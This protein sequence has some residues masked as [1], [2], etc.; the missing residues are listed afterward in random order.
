VL[1]EHD[2]RGTREGELAGLLVDHVDLAGILAGW[3]VFERNLELDGGG[4]GPP[5]RCPPLPSK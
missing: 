3:D 1:L 2:N 5:A 4:I